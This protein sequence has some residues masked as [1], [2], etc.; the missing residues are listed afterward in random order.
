[1][2]PYYEED[3][4]LRYNCNYATHLRMRLWIARPSIETLCHPSQL[5]EA[6]KDGGALYRHKSCTAKSMADQAPE[7]THRFQEF[8]SARVFPREG[9]CGIRTM[10]AGAH[11]CDGA[12]SWSQASGE[13]SSA[14]Y[15]RQSAEQ[16]LN[17]PLSLPG[18][19]APQRRPQF[20]GCRTTALTCRW[21]SGLQ[22]RQI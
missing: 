21:S 11:T 6:S 15:R 17:E 12:R 10:G 19:I 7:T 3:G 4:I 9:T 16:R 22:G 14:P 5:E 1:M 13:R 18:P 2:K 8:G 20:S